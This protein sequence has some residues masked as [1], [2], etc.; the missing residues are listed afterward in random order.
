MSIRPETLKRYEENLK[1]DNS[2]L[3]AMNAVTQN[4]IHASALSVEALK[5]N[6]HE[7]SE[8]IPNGQITNQKR[9]GRCWMFAALN[10]M[11][12]PIIQKYELEN[13]ELSQS[14]PLFFD[15]LE[16]ANFFLESILETLDEP[17][18]GRILSFLLSSPMN[19]GGQFDMFA[20]LVEKYG[21]VPKTAMPETACSS[22]TQQ[23]DKYLTLKLREFARSLRKG[24]EEGLSLE[25]LKS[26]KEG[27]LQQIYRILCI[28]LGFP[29][30]QVDFLVRDKNGVLH[31]EDHLSPVQFYQKYVGW[32]LK[33][34]VSLI[35]APTKDKPYHR[36]YT[37]RFLGNVKEARPVRYLN[38][39]IEDL[40]AAAIKQLKAG[41]PVWFGCDVGQRSNRESGVM[42]IKALNVEGLLG[43]EFPLDKAERLDYGESLMTHAMVLLGVHLDEDGRPRRWKVENSWG[44]DVGHE[45]YYL[46]D[47]EW[48]SEYCYQVVIKRDY[49]PES[50]L[51]EYEGEVTRLEPWD[52][53]GSLA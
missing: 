42:D 6:I 13:F 10:T 34:Y 3:I 17:L 38:L 47:D 7:Y 39:P 33:N 4:G 14:Y 15:K 9:S 50:F 23:M 29:P 40:K 26:Q 51:K 8:S 32:D 30:E 20:A 18:S 27:M 36:A 41:E 49:L 21:V 12:Q 22:D 28:C 24:H 52:P 48:F 16:K 35:N 31:R 43:L 19:D 11:R 1:R 45:G 46:M 5:K 53:M 44:K 25:A 2:A 37:V